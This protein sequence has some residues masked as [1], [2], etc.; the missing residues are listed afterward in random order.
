MKLLSIRDAAERIG[1]RP[2]KLKRLIAEGKGPK[3][4]NLGKRTT[5]IKESDLI[6]WHSNL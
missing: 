1:L 6:E 5:F 3:A 4:S 2:A